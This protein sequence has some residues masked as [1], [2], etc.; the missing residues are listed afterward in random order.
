[1]KTS[2]IIALIVLLVLLDQIIK[3]VIYNYYLD[4][5][6][7]IIPSL[8]EFKPVFNN[9]GT[10]FAILLKINGYVFNAIQAF[11]QFLLSC[12]MVVLYIFMKKAG[13]STKVFE[14]F[15]IFGQSSLI[16]YFVSI[17]FWEKGV[18]DF[19]FLKPYFIFDLKDIYGSCFICLL[20]VVM[21]KYKIKKFSDIR[22]LVKR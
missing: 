9:K 11:F 18:L 4:C 5:N 16:C 13:N 19:I 3:I 14:W 1:M 12:L 17:L 7:S 21:H 8:L 10:Y 6:F 22:K 15:L 2:K 20:F